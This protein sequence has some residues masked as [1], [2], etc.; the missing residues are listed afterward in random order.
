MTFDQHGELLRVALLK[1]RY[2][3]MMIGDVGYDS[4]QN[5]APAIGTNWG[6]LLLL[7]FVLFANESTETKWSKATHAGAARLVGPKPKALSS[8]RESMG[9]TGT[10]FY[11][12]NPTQKTAKRQ[13]RGG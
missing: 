5:P 2:T 11:L 13:R 6:K 3:E 7:Q 12:K 9:F 8:K 10:E 1:L 4:R